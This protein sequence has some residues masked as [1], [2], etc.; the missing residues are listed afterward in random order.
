MVVEVVV[1]AAAAAAAAAAFRRRRAKPSRLK[2]LLLEE[3]QDGARMAGG[4]AL[5]PLAQQL[6]QLERR[7]PGGGRSERAVG[8]GGEQHADAL[9]T[10]LP[11]S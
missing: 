2:R 11:Q 5:L 10:T 7:A 3:R 8:A 6:C 9:E 1:P 4:V